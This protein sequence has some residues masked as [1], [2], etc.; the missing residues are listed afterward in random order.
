MKVF[1]IPEWTL[2]NTTFLPTSE[3]MLISQPT[4]ISGPRFYWDFFTPRCKGS[5]EVCI[6]KFFFSL[7]NTSLA[8]E[9]E[10]HL[11][12]KI[13]GWPNCLGWNECWLKCTWL[14]WLVAEM[15]WL[16]WPWRI[17]FG[18]NDPTP[19]GELWDPKC[20]VFLISCASENEWSR[21]TELFR[22]VPPLYF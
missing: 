19:R 14:K 1:V 10:L 18:G 2:K 6:L 9:P 17:G 3:K 5:N 11:N 16:K 4:D 21:P 15:T 7:Y 13:L 12:Q 8:S 22:L 20:S